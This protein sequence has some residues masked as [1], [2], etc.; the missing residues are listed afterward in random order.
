MAMRPRDHYDFKTITEK[1]QTR[2]AESNVFEAR[3]DDPK[4][5][6]YA[7]EMFVYPSG[8]VHIGHVRNYSIGDVY[9]RYKRMQGYNVLHPFGYDAFGLPAEN[10]A[11]KYSTHPETWTLDN[12]AQIRGQ[13][14]RMGLS[15]DWSREVITC[16][17]EYYKWNQWFFIKMY[18]RGLAYRK[19]G[20]VNWCLECNTVLAND[21]VK[22]GCCWRHTETP[23]IQKE[24]E[25]WYFRITAYAEELLRDTYDLPDWPEKVLIMQRNWI[26]KSEGADV[27]FR[28]E[29]SD[30]SITIFTTRIDTIYGASAVLISPEHPIVWE[31]IR[32]NRLRADILEYVEKL[33]NKI[34]SKRLAAE[35]GEL[36]K[37]GLFTGRTARNPFS[38]ETLPIWISNFV[39]M[40]Y[41]TGAI[42][43]VPAHDERDFEFSKKYNLP[44][45]VVVQPHDGKIKEGDVTSAFTEY[46]RLSNSGPFTGL[47]SEE[48][49]R[50][51]IKYAE[52]KGFGRA[53]V[54]YRLQDWVI[55]RQR[56]WGTPIPMIYC[57]HCG[58]VPVPLET[59][60]VVLPKIKEFKPTSGSPLARCDEFVNT[61]CPRCQRRAR[62]ETDTMDT[63][64]DSSWYFYR[65]LD[66]RNEAVPFRT[67]LVDKWFPI[68]WYIGGIEHATGHLLFMRFFTKVMRDLGLVHLNEP[69]IK[70]FPQGMV[71]KDG[72]AMS[73]SRGNVVD[74]DTISG[75]YGVDTLRLFV[76]FAAPPESDMDWNDAGIEGPH[77]FVNRVYRIVSDFAEKVK[78]RHYLDAGTPLNE[79]EKKLLRRMHQTIK[80]VTIDIGERLHLNTAIS[81]VMEFVNDIYAFTAKEPLREE[82]LRLLKSAFENVVLLLSP[83]T[84]HLCEELW[85][86]LGHKGGLTFVPWPKYDPELAKEEQIEV[87]VQINGKM[88]A[89]VFTD[90]GADEEKIKALARTDS[91]VEQY[92]RGKRV[93][94]TIYVPK[95]LVNIVVAEP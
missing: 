86:R 58:V 52:E 46:G 59:L 20:W 93:V 77:R 30:K 81:A 5:K 75:K 41:G 9:S 92:L 50:R 10:A 43:S 22:D 25:Q 88:R 15:Y 91:K 79:D 17:P 64:V 57:D 7:L 23:V 83:F 51:M 94:R 3:D 73:K 80:R 84:P 49:I 21:Q 62:R 33:K 65:Y 69:V 6:F 90:V 67:E 61:T 76:L 11:I 8:T 37:E 45:P 18:E 27:D 95:K 87:V 35:Q 19:F 13:L 48:A 85:E 70:Y 68:E 14:K 74:P 29:G 63:F 60:P 1:W 55:S 72:S 4:E 28:V 38:G 34:R 56:F 2:W 78:G 39:L 66:P 12:I 44:T 16:L 32:G 54:T 26:G 89:R 36:E 53:R 40:E 24:L 82:S 47:G 71:T 42:M 31:L